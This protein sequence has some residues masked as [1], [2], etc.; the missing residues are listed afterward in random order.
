MGMVEGASACG[1]S[2]DGGQETPEDAQG[3]WCT[4]Q[5]WSYTCQSCI[6]GTDRSACR[7]QCC[8]QHALVFATYALA[9]WR[10]RNRSCGGEQAAARCQNNS[11]HAQGGGSRGQFD[12]CPSPRECRQQWQ[13]AATRLRR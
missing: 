2:S 3:E 10:S 4:Q 7:C 6:Y 8:G 12:G 13:L 5:C 9:G 1:R 11:R